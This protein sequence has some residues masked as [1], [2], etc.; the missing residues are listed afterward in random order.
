MNLPD[1]HMQRP[2]V[3]ASL[4]R[5]G[6]VGIRMPVGCAVMGDRPIMVVPVFDAYINL[7][8]DLKGVH[9]SRNYEA[10]NDVMR[11]HA[12]K[13]HKLEDVCVSIATELLKRHEYASRAEVR[14]RAKVIYEK[15]TPKTEIQTYETCNLVGRAIARRADG[16]IRVTKAVGVGV[17]GITTCPCARGTVKEIVANRL[18]ESAQLPEETIKKLMDG[19][20]I[21]T[22]MQRAYGSITSQVP[23][24][25]E[26]DVMDH[27]NIIQGSMS[28]ST[29]ELLKRVD[30]ADVV[31]KAVTNPRFVEDCIRFMMEGFVKKFSKL[32]DET[33]VT[34]RMR[35]VESIHNHDLMASRN[36]TLGALRKEIG[37]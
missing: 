25:V 11:E 5:V 12:A 27:I 29:Y 8:M 37:A 16:D 30:E 17:T 2:P 21:A 7:P 20:P 28:A 13:R 4:N 34:F 36:D 1:V 15:M 33:K 26:V 22:H 3:T 32:P 18:A 9:A 31:L 6:V 10:I 35:S 24:G 14:A 19:L 23:L